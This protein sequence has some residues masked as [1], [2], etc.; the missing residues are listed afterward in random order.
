MKIGATLA[1]NIMETKKATNQ[2]KGENVYKFL[3]F[4]TFN[5]LVRRPYKL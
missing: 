2:L 4:P 3:E 1:E 5:K